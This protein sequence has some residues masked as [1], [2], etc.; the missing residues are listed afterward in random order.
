MRFLSQLHV[1]VFGAV[2]AGSSVDTFPDDIAEGSSVA[3]GEAET[4]DSPA[5]TDLEGYT[6][7]DE[8][9]PINIGDSDGDSFDAESVN[10]GYSNGNT[11]VAIVSTDPRLEE[12]MTDMF[13]NIGRAIYNYLLG[14]LMEEAVAEDEIVVDTSS[15]ADQVLEDDFDSSTTTPSPSTETI[16]VSDISTSVSV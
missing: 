12:I 9:E 2:V 10:D 8:N 4:S 7:E 6:A 14:T 13:L 11:L 15:A 5:V 16:E 1:L 3:T